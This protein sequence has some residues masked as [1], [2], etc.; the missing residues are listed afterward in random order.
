[1]PV[2]SN[3]SDG[4]ARW[5]LNLQLKYTYKI[6]Y[7]VQHNQGVNKTEKRSYLIIAATNKWSLQSDDLLI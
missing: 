5:R 2:L 7:T 3:K 6:S 1:M 4:N